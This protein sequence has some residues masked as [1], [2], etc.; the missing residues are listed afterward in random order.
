MASTGR[1]GAR[2]RRPLTL[3]L[4]GIIR[5]AWQPLLARLNLQPGLN[6]HI[7]REDTP[8]LEKAFAIHLNN[9]TAISAGEF[10]FSLRSSQVGQWEGALRRLSLNAEGTIES[11][12]VPLHGWNAAA[13]GLRIA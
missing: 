7:P 9:R 8:Q 6:W 4:S 13:V 1:A 3:A 5:F 12:K 11:S 2:Q 10:P